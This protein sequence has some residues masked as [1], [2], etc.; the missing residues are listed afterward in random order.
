MDNST[1]KGLSAGVIVITIIIVIICIVMAI[2][3][4]DD[5][6]YRVMYE[7]EPEI[8]DVQTICLGDTYYDKKSKEDKLF[9]QIEITLNND[10]NVPA[11]K[12]S[13]GYYYD[14]NSHDYVDIVHDNG[15]L[16][17]S[18]TYL[19][20]AGATG[21]VRAIV[22][23]PENASKLYISSLLDHTMEVLVDLER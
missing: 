20:P 9:Y 22:E 1:K 17:Y 12:H 18:D 15:N 21:K 3:H 2:S 6:Y 16:D 7:M 14:S 23:I 4:G 8:I 13:T 11:E 5:T 10:S 19:I